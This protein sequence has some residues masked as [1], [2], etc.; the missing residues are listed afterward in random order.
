V[1]KKILPNVG[2]KRVYLSP[3]CGLGEYLP[4]EIAFKKLQNMIAIAEKVRELI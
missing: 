1:L 4:R 3:S 2:S